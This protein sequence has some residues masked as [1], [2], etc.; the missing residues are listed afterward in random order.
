MFHPKMIMFLFEISVPKSEIDRVSSLVNNARNLPTI[1]DT[2]IRGLN[3][4]KNRMDTIENRMEALER[5]SKE[6][7]ALVVATAL[8]LREKKTRNVSVMLQRSEGDHMTPSKRSLEMRWMLQE[9]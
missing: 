6:Q 1:V 5:L 7:E 4:V 3:S 2:M 8:L 9:G